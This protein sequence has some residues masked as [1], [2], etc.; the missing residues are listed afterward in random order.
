MPREFG[1]NKSHEKAW[2]LFLS[3]DEPCCV[4]LEDDVKPTVADLTGAIVN[5]LKKMPRDI[6]MLYLFGPSHPGDRI[7]LNS[8]A[9][10]KWVR[11]LMGYWINRRAAKLMIEAA[12]PAVYQTDYQIP[13]RLFDGIKGKLSS[14]QFPKEINML[15]SVRSYGLFDPLIEHSEYAKKSTFTNTGDKPWIPKEMLP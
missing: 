4:V 3:T 7:Q 8:D 6:D 2:S 15:P 1:C 12:I 5:K 13:F 14:K 9:T 11:S 10:V